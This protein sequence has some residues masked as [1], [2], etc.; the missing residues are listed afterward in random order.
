MVISM[1]IKQ[2]MMKW[3][4]VCLTMTMLTGCTGQAEPT[5]AVQDETMEQV[6]ETGTE[7]TETQ[8]EQDDRL[9]W[10]DRITEDAC[11][12]L[13]DNGR[14]DQ[15]LRKLSDG[16]QVTIAAIGGSV[17]EGAGAS[18]TQDCY[19]SRFISGLQERYPDADIQ[20]VNAGVGGTP[21][22]LGVIRYERDVT[23]AL[24]CDPDLVLVE[25]AVNDYEEPTG[26]RAY[27]SLVRNIL[28]KDNEPAVLLVFSVFKTK[29]NLQD[30]YE[31]VGKLYGLPMVS[32]K[33]GIKGAYD[34][35]KLTDDMFFS[36]EYHPTG[37]GHKIMA[38][39][40]LYLIDQ[41]QEKATDEIA[42][43]PEKTVYGVD[44]EQMHMLTAKTD[45]EGLVQTGDF[46]GTDTA[47]QHTPHMKEAVFADNWMHAKDAGNS[48][49]QAKLNCRNIL[50]N[51]KTGNDASFGKASV[52]ID[53]EFVTEVSGY[54][55]G[56]WNNSN[57][58]LVLDEQETKEHMLEVKMSEGEEARA[59]TIQ[60]I[61]YSDGEETATEAES[62]REDMSLSGKY[63]GDF[64][65]GVALPA[66][67]LGS[68][69]RYDD[70]IQNNF[71]IMTCENETKPDA[72]LDQRASQSGLPRTYEN[73][74]VHFDACQPA[75]E[76]ALKNNMKLRLHTLVWH[77]QTPRWFFTED[78]TNEGELVDREVMLKR[79][80]AY[81]R[82]VL[83]YFDT[84]YSGL[85]YAVDVVNEAFDVGNGDQN[86]VRQKDNLWYET[87]G[88]DYYYHAF[89]SARKYAPSYMKLFYNDYGCSGKVDLILER[90]SQ[91]KEEGLIDGI[92]MQSHLSTEDDIQHKFVY[93]AKAFCDAGYE[94]QITELDIGI[95]GAKTED[96]YKKQARKYRSLFKNMQEMAEDG[97]PVTAVIVWGLNDQL[98]WRRG[99]DAL[100]FDGVMNPKAAY[101]GALQDDSVPDI[102]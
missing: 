58:I 87:V 1:K 77:S 91:A 12:S 24:G 64:P 42:Q 96:A 80:D 28:L 70:V 33:D 22:T 29:W 18:N 69:S 6:T 84:Q 78:Y 13:G 89:V 92:G 7:Q 82:S 79:M 67:V 73:P 59:F 95:K 101:Y 56:G 72:L 3:M 98:S 50:L 55:K 83:E 86:G 31:P 27:E 74:C 19:V 34:S 100:L 61:G 45:T 88:D 71:N 53:G 5:A 94:L 63:A 2:N 49:F 14:L 4:G 47:L 15:V 97:Y 17:T 20:Y 68:I 66:H 62:D 85:I 41:K 32:I 16:E 44:F 11:M 48:P 65:I 10:Y 43:L 38:D 81:I 76:Y 46:N 39:S 52:Y 60:C 23:Q 90:L 75:V 102:E 40:L 99:E 57:I 51:Y 35:G 30:I 93:A 8:E 54:D 9:A 37:F 25:F 26:G 36:D 21:S